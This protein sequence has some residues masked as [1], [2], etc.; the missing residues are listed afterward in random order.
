MCI[1][2]R[3]YQ[4]DA[5]NKLLECYKNGATSVLLVLPTGGG[6][7]IVFTDIT[8]KSVLTRGKKVLLLVHREELLNQTSKSLTRFNVPHGL[9]AAN[10]TPAYY[11]PAQI[12]SVQTLVNRL[13]EYKRHVG[14]PDFI[15]IDEA[16]HAV[17]GSWKTIIEEFPN[18]K[19]LGVTAT[20]QRLD[21]KGLGVHCG[22]IFEEIVIGATVTE[23]IGHGHLT[24]PVIYAPPAETDKATITGSVI[25]HY[26]RL[27]QGLPTVVFCS[28]VKHAQQVA[29]DFRDAGITAECLDASIEKGKR[30]QI[31]AGLG[32]GEIQ[33]VTSCD[34]ISEGTDIPAIGCAILLRKTTSLSL[35]LQQV[36]RALRVCE[37]KEYA[38]ILDHVGN[39]LRHGLPTDE[40]DWSLNGGAKRKGKA[41]KDLLLKTCPSCYF[42]HKP[43][44]DNICPKCKH[45][46]EVKERKVILQDGDLV[47]ITAKVA[48][49]KKQER[50]EQGRA[51]T[52]NDL[53]E[54]AKRTGRKPQWAHYVY[55][56]RKKK[57]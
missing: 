16:H 20:P 31:I 1:H 9:I 35:Y 23:L 12:A 19:I 14:A 33:V 30:A 39:S 7:T 40:Y 22:G 45:R 29:E 36:G 38:I 24:E 3:D 4:Q 5:E 13:A 37:G 27:A 6:K 54:L 34:I 41:A 10:K 21:G 44:A 52:L 32:N 55:N 8:S 53:L 56:S 2:L 17:A 50:M 28:N 15:I 48:A 43:T 51:Q 11:K 25:G 47:E 18:A 46:P 57:T 26:K 49:A 42:T